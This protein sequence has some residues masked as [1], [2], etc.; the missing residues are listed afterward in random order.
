MLKMLTLTSLKD[1]IKL[2]DKYITFFIAMRQNDMPQDVIGYIVNMLPQSLPKL[3]KFNKDIKDIAAYKNI[4][5]TPDTYYLLNFIIQVFLYKTIQNARLISQYRRV[6][7]TNTKDIEYALGIYH[8]E[9]LDLTDILIKAGDKA[10]N[11][12]N[13]NT[14]DRSYKVRANVLI[15][16][17]TIANIILMKKVTHRD[18]IKTTANVSIFLAGVIEKL[19]TYIIKMT[20][21]NN[22][23]VDAIIEA[24]HT[25]NDLHIM[26]LDLYI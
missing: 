3:T 22:I 9:G 12:F 7:L 14:S 2:R 4:K 26:F 1:Y 19:I 11:K 10:L 25:D 15:T 18:P 20:G 5:L 24:I 17:I 23:H 16:P 21:K 13:E 6:H 8:K